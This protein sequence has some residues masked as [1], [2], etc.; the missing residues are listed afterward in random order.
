M[1]YDVTCS[2]CGLST[3]IDDL[4]AVF[5]LQAEHRERRG[6]HHVLEFVRLASADGGE[7]AV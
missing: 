3:E 7:D 5:D 2:V 4:D 1:C 6:D